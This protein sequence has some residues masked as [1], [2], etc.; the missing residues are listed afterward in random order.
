M[1]SRYAQL[2]AIE[3]AEIQVLQLYSKLVHCTLHTVKNHGVRSKS[4]GGEAAFANTETTKY[5]RR[6]QSR[7]W[8]QTLDWAFTV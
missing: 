8:R 4:F 6:V 3:E 1:Y 7:V 5:V 2:R